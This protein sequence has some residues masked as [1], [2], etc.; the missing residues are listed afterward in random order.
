MSLKLSRGFALLLGLLPLS[1]LANCSGRSGGEQR[2]AYDALLNPEGGVDVIRTGVPDPGPTRNNCGMRD[3][4]DFSIQHNFEKS[5]TDNCT[6]SPT[7]GTTLYA[8][9]TWFIF[10]DGTTDFIKPGALEMRI[11]ESMLPAEPTWGLDAYPAANLP[12]GAPCPESL[13]ILRLWG[14][15]FELWGGGIGSGYFNEQFEQGPKDFSMYD[16]ISFWARRG[17]EG[18][19]ALRVNLIDEQISETFARD[20]YEKR[21]QQ[22]PPYCK[23]AMRCDCLNGMPCELYDP[24]QHGKTGEPAYYCWDPNAVP[25]ILPDDPQPDPKG[26]LNPDG[27]PQV[28]DPSNLKYN[29][30]KPKVCGNTWCQTPPI[31][32]DGANV[33]SVCTERLF[34]NNLTGKYCGNPEQH[35][36]EPTERCGNAYSAI[37]QVDMEWKLYTIPWEEMLQADY[38]YKGTAL[39]PTKLYSIG[40]GWV[41]GW[42]DFYIDDVGFY[43]RK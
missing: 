14:G 19:S 18:Q 3:A 36:P 40:F 42:V 29:T 16:G 11:P 30:I 10:S 38:A 32:N 2:A 21:P 41:G 17:P 23:V 43:K 33:G 7:A 13:G 28:R 15:P 6:T 35:I 1:I 25:L 34:E 39:D 8:A 31:D 12:G 27:T 24:A 4:F 20:F 26:C 9:P 5:L 22:E 37:V